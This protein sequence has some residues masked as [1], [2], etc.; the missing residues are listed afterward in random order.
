MGLVRFTAVEP[1]DVDRA[2]EIGLSP[3]SWETT[4]TSIVAD[5]A[6]GV[7][8]YGVEVPCR[9][10]RGFYDV[11]RRR[12]G[13]LSRFSFGRHEITFDKRG[14]ETHGIAAG[15]TVVLRP[16]TLGVR[17]V[18]A[19]PVRKAARALPR[20]PVEELGRELAGSPLADLDA[21]A[22][23]ALPDT[24]VVRALHRCRSDLFAT[25]TDLTA[26]FLDFDVEQAFGYDDEDADEATAWAQAS[27]RA[28]D[29]GEAVGVVS[30]REAV[31]T[32]VMLD[33]RVRRIL[34][35]SETGTFEAK[36]ADGVSIRVPAEIGYR[37]VDHLAIAVAQAL[38]G[39]GDDGRRLGRP[40][41]EFAADLFE[42]HLANAARRY[43]R[44]GRAPEGGLVSWDL[45]EPGS[46]GPYDPGD[47]GE[48]P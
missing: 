45:Y 48:A 31:R 13:R 5:G 47:E 25:G 8:V 16:G 36:P 12:D 3:R 2:G 9:A 6:S 19:A 38:A 7:F 17:R 40:V 30:D 1:V 44:S 23:A 39:P 41:A 18:L 20:A 21:Q 43:Q 26:A 29:P 34:E 28:A 42:S 46:H 15:H 27:V 14:G 10:E 33:E 32:A 35:L 4:A 24:D 37:A 11:L 22:R